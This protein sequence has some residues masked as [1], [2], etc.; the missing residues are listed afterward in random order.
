MSI[1]IC[2]I[3]VAIC[4]CVC[5]GTSNNDY[6]CGGD[7]D[8]FDK[9]IISSLKSSGY[10]VEEGY[11]R[12]YS[13][14]SAYAA[15]PSLFYGLFVFNRSK[16]LQTKREF[17]GL[18]HK[19]IA[20]ER[21]HLLLNLNNIRPHMNY[22]EFWYMYGN[23]AVIWYGCHA[24]ANYYSYR[25]YQNRR[26]N[27]KHPDSRYNDTQNNN[28]KYPETDTY[29]SLGDM[30][31]NMNIHSTLN[32]LQIVVSTPDNKT[33]TDIR[34]TVLQ[35]N[36]LDLLHLSDTDQ[37]NLDIMPYTNI[38]VD[39]PGF[40]A[41]GNT[42]NIY[43]LKYPGTY[44]AERQILDGETLDGI[45][46]MVRF[47]L[48]FTNASDDVIQQ[49]LNTKQKVYRIYLDPS[50]THD[51]THWDEPR[52]PFAQPFVHNLST[53]RYEQDELQPYFMQ[54]SDLVYKYFNGFGAQNEF[55][56][57][58]TKISQPF[59]NS[60]HKYGFNCIKYGTRCMADNRDAQYFLT[61]PDYSVMSNTSV[62]ILMGVVHREMGKC[63]WENL[64]PYF[65]NS[66]VNSKYFRSHYLDYLSTKYRDS[67]RKFPPNINETGKIPNDVLN[68][69]FIVA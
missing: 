35:A 38:P 24:P 37:I 14:Q 52:E 7:Y 9:N 66:G 1:N 57:V 11:L 28:E 12:W 21:D 67:A 20:H 68:K 26:M 50:A 51:E 18:R 59:Y 63:E 4:V 5:H 43:Y 40:G 48:P 69:F 49:Y 55:R 13:N 32:G 31:N 53:D 44:G 23:E 25:S 42:T 10:L 62:F 17:D 15:N 61:W 2:S 30:L 60:N 34:N 47:G 16:P 36:N 33:F 39:G 27:P 54:Y 56:Y 6:T 8:V 41:E 58:S 3:L 29:G 64:V 65:A 45:G 19:H 22:D 46:I